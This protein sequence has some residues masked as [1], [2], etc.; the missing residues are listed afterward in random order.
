MKSGAGSG[1]R[2][3]AGAGEP[4]GWTGS[5]GRIATVLAVALVL[6]GGMIGLAV[7]HAAPGSRSAAAEPQRK[8][9]TGAR[10]RTRRE[11]AARTARRGFRDGRRDGIRHGRM[12]GSRSGRTAGRIAIAQSG[13]ES[14]QADAAAA[15]AELAGMTAAPPA[16]AP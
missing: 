3:A 2:P 9:V 13:L 16:P 14:A 5:R 15:Q 8:A 10:D 7:G 4:P 1:P 6:A 12:T 11:V